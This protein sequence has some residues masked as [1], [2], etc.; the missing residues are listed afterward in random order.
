[1]GPSATQTTSA[2]SAPSPAGAVGSE[3]YTLAAHHKWRCVNWTQAQRL[4]ALAP[5]PAGSYWQQKRDLL[6]SA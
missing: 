2:E 1:M 5:K 4:R 6:H 3:N